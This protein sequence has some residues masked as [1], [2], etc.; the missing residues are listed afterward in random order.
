VVGFDQPSVV[1][2]ITVDGGADV[3]EFGEEVH[4]VI[5]VVLPIFGFADA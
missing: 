5:E 2:F 1:V 4:G 3:G